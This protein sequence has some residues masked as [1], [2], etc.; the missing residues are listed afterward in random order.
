MFDGIQQHIWKIVII[1]G[2]MLLPNIFDLNSAAAERKNPEKP[3]TLE[4][5]FT[6]SGPG[7]TKVFTVA[8]GWKIQWKTDSPSFKLSAHGSARRPYVGPTSERD[9]ILRQFETVHP[10][11]LANTTKTNGTAVHPLGGTFYFTILADGPWSIHLT[12][13]KDTKDYLDVPYTGAP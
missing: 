7:E 12:T 13:I 3:F 1:I 4:M 9:A 2:L 8:D 11:V 5:T 6:G 10:I